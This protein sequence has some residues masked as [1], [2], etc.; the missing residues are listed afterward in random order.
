M[1][2]TYGYTEIIKRNIIQQF[3][4]VR[5]YDCDDILEYISSSFGAFF[6]SK[7]LVEISKEIRTL[8]E[9]KYLL[10]SAVEILHYATLLHDDIIDD[11]QYRRNKESL[12]TVFGHKIAVLTGDLLFGI[13]G[14]IITQCGQELL[15]KYIMDAVL[16]LSMGELSEFR[17]SGKSNGKLED[18]LRIID[19]KTGSLFG[20][21][22]LFATLKDKKVKPE[23]YEKGI[24]FGR[25][26]QIIDDTKD[27]MLEYED[28]TKPVFND[29]RSGILTYPLMLLLKK[30]EDE[31]KSFLFQ[32]FGHNLSDPEIKRIRN[33]FYRYGIFR[34]IYFDLFDKIKNIF[35]ELELKNSA[36]LMNL[37]REMAGPIYRQGV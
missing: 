5:L 19:D 20:L 22:F 23:F 2:D 25:Y 32:K 24:K 27:Y 9:A 30:A 16:R 4:S 17:F 12:H 10:A 29:F 7:I 31:E 6:R 35:E 8:D 13:A 1:Q 26:F 36:P 15:Y 11:C 28:N 33:I 37:A 14:R 3:Y 21:A 34:E 18:Y